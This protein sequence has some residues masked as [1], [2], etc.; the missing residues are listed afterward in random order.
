W[1]GILLAMLSVMVFIVPIGMIYAISNIQ[2][3]T[4]V[5]TEFLFGLG[6]PGKAIANVC[7]KTYGSNALSMA[8]NLITDLKL[9]VYMKIPPKSMFITQ[10]YATLIGGVVNY[11]VMDELIRNVPD[12]CANHQ[13]GKTFNPEWGATNTK[14]FYTASLIWGAIAPKRMFGSDSPYHPLLWCFLGGVVIPI[15]C[16]LLHRRY[17]NFGWN[18]VNWPIFLYAWG[19][20]PVNGSG[21]SY[22]MILVTSYLSQFYA[23]R[24]RRNWYDK[25]NYTI[26]AALDSGTIC[27]AIIL[28]LTVTLA[29]LGGGPGQQ[30]GSYVFWALNPNVTQYADQDYCLNYTP[31]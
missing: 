10:L 13:P 22:V 12:I 26:S 17:P 5:I 18:L 8:N 6:V 23:K 9:A 7:F 20:G 21:S 29:K 25:Y 14:I 4:N 28:Y 2:I 15:P 30:Q 24:Y 16:F 27:T 19:G 3:G 31:V 11:A 1:W